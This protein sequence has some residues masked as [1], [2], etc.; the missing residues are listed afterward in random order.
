MRQA[1][2]PSGFPSIMTSHSVEMRVR[3]IVQG[4]GF[5]PTVWRIA[6]ELELA[7]DVRND[8]QGVL[9]R[10]EGPGDAIEQFARRLVL[11][12]PLLARIDAIERTILHDGIA[13]SGF[14]IAPSLPGVMATAIVPDSATCKA[15]LAEV[16]TPSERRCGHP[17]ANCTNCGPRLTII[18][19][20]PYDRANTTMRGFS[21]CSACAA[22]YADP[23]DRRFH[24]QPIACPRCGPALT[25]SRM[26]GGALDRS[27]DPD[28]ITA[29]AALMAQ[30]AIVALKGLGGFHLACDATNAETVAELRRRKRR[31]GKAFAVMMPDVAVARRWCAVSDAEET[32]LLSPEAPIVL[33]EAC[34]RQR[35][36]EAIAPGL[37][38]VGVM[39][40][41][42][43]LHHLLMGELARPAVMTSGNLSDEPQ[44]V[45]GEQA[46]ARLGSIADYLLDHDRPIVNRV[47]DSVVRV[48]AGRPAV[49]RRA[50]GFAPTPLRLP[51]GFAS[52]PP[53][54]AMG[55]ELKATF[56]LIKD[57]QAI[58]SQHLGDLEN[59]ATFDDY[60]RTLGLYQR[61]F[62]HA[63]RACAV[64]RHPEYLS[65]KLGR[66]MA[67]DRELAIMEIQHHHAHIAACLAENGVA[68]DSA[69]VLGVAL[70]GLGLGDD[71]T[72]WGGE[73]LLADYRDWRRVGALEAIA[74]PGGAQSIKEPWRNTLAHI[75]A[76]MDW[77]AFEAR[78]SGTP[79]HAVLAA[80]PVR[81]IAS[82]IRSGANTPLASSC[83]RLFDAVAG[84]VGV[85]ADRQ[86]YEGEA[87]ARLEALVDPYTLA[88]MPDREAYPFAV[89][90]DGEGMRRL[91]PDP[92]WQTLLADLAAGAPAS[93]ISTRFHGGLAIAVADLA[94]DLLRACDSETARTVVLSGG[95]FQN[96]LLL[97]RVKARLEADSVNVLIH[98]KV[99]A[100]DGGLSLGQAVIAAAR[101]V[102]ADH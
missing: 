13:L 21:M 66:D 58:L 99:P 52:S 3:G 90:E 92:M 33:L 55:G 5:R 2:G 49:I 31:F 47:D 4:V 84:A 71:D 78:F 45:G 60:R 69:P 29:T 8:A 23:A 26:G 7:G 100:N 93:A 38:T 20:A 17:F 18:E 95:C 64:D 53:L 16:R 11:E 44:C 74:M 98:A 30:G 54:L 77:S 51:D 63:P 61:L 6:T 97:E 41:Y 86:S 83:G 24:A 102:A 59:A 46:R 88:R 76:V 82:M 37:R 81:A 36:P 42:T 67:E 80:K 43:P 94:A 72:I 73:F 28:P 87:A 22:E 9:I 68:L 56:C 91:D 75:L 19:A 14:R 27:L 39:L 62:D 15:C 70:D 35:L 101:S 32:L 57:G 96:S 50:R 79:L 10:L 1:V 12:A 89:E 25:L 40:P 85:A 48:M 34:G 65:S